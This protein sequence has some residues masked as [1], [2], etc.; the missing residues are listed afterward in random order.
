VAETKL[1]SDLGPYLQ[2]D[3]MAGKQFRVD[4]GSFLELNVVADVTI[5]N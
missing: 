3:A 5:C 2:L 1:R 4:F